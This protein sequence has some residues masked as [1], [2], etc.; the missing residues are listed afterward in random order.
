[1]RPLVNNPPTAHMKE[2]ILVTGA[3]RSGTTWVGRML[4]ASDHVAYINEP[5][6]PLTRDVL[7]PLR[8]AGQ[9]SYIC[10]ANEED[11]LGPFERLL[12]F[13]YPTRTEIGAVRSVADVLRMGRR[14]AQFA[15]ARSS[16]K[17]P[18]LK[19][20]FAVFSAPWFS[21]RLGC[22]VVMTV[23]HPV[24][25]VSSFVRLGWRVDFEAILSQPLLVRDLLCSFEP[26]M[27]RMMH[28]RRDGVGQACLLWNMIYSVVHRYAT[29]F[30]SFIVVRHEDFSTDA[31]GRYKRLYASLGLEFCERAERTIRAASSDINPSEVDVSQPHGVRIDSRANLENW[32][33][34]LESRDVG[35]IQELTGELAA[36]FYGELSW[37]QSC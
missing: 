37:P 26:E 36:R 22:R 15:A 20:P 29:E 31:V 13:R 3:Q 34:R 18:L 32:R 8:V 12:S 25:V 14:W 17:R 1:M 27:R 28:Q 35:R 10:P 21:Q 16:G 19:D 6:N 2:P 5:L 11:F 7:V 33:H 9:Y 23:R 30:P 4:E 24:A